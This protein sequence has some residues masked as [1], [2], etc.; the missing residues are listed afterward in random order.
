MLSI[1]LGIVTRRAHVISTREATIWTIIWIAI[2]MIFNAI[3]YI[4][5][6]G[7]KALEFLSG[8]I[9]EK[10]LSVDNLFVF[11][12]IFRYFDIQPLYQPRVLRYG[13]LGALLLRAMFIFAGTA[14]I[15]TFHP[16]IFIFG[17]FLVVTGLRLLREK[18]RKIRPER[19]PLV[20]LLRKMFPI[21]SELHGQ[22][23]FIKQGGHRY[24]TLLL[25]VLLVVESTDLVFA[26]DSI[27]AVFAITTDFFIVYTS[28]A[29]AILGL[30]AMYFILA[31][32]VPRFTY[33]RAG[34]AAILVFVGFKML[35][36]DF[37]E[38]SVLASLV[39]ISGI[40]G[41]AGLISYLHNRHVT[42][43]SGS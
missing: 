38:I 36:S 39:V 27:P 16:M 32:V 35:L 43:G 1:D 18:Q 4:F 40:L 5:V 41:L 28:N 7:Q 25:L 11:L 19:N 3:I 33:L 17:G 22:K 34:L 12:V 6:N 42:A 26:T 29:F 8:Y 14:A 15:E 20:R 2:S 24:A 30:R 9:I 21:T 23:F 37:V 31:S 10:S 13:V